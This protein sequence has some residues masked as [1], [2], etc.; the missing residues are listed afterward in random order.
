MVSGLA[1]AA[2]NLAGRIESHGATIS[3]EEAVK[4]SVILPFLQALGYDVFNPAE[5]VPEFTADTIGKKGEKVDYAILREGEVAILMECKSLSTELG[6]KHLSQLYRYFTVTNARF[7]I[8]TN[9]Q[10]YQFYSDLAEPHRL[11]KRPFFT[12][13]LL[14]FNEGS[15]EELAKFGRSS[16]DIENILAQA[17][18]LKFVAAI[19]PILNG[20][21]ADPSDEFVKLIA[22]QVYEGRLSPSI[23]TTVAIATKAAFREIMRDKVRARL[24]TALEDPEANEIEES[25][26]QQSEIVTTEEEVEGFLLIKSLLRGTLDTSRVTIR[27]AKSYCAVLLDDNNRKP[28]ARLHFN[29]SQKYFGLFDG[30]VE[31]RIAIETLD[32]ILDFKDRITATALKYG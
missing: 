23:R 21:I 24:N 22:G 16:F 2:K 26:P 8:L 28:L 19:K 29:R 18:R 15:L 12:F 30:E 25:T 27:D 9:G 20:L 32:D 5:V 10:V 17:E 13:D 31:E 6:E 3:T 1:E 11:D 4:T 7:A 14:D